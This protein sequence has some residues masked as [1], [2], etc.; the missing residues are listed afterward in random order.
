[1]SD[2][3]KYVGDKLLNYPTISL[4]KS[5]ELKITELVIKKLNLRDIGQLRDRFEGQAY[6]DNQILKISSYI[7]LLKFFN[8]NV[9]EININHLKDELYI[10][11]Q[12]KK[13]EIIPTSTNTLPS[14]DINKV[15]NPAIVVIQ[16]GSQNYSVAGFISLD[17]LSNNDNFRKKGLRESEFI[18][19]NNLIEFNEI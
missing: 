13:Y 15:K 14:L 17:M 7:A 3:F 19:F 16:K 1:M 11:Y 18:G 2:F 4:S 9:P 12:K 10:I 6:L 5:I 8:K